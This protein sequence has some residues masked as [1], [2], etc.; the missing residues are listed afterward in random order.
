MEVAARR[1]FRAWATAVALV[2]G[3]AFL[4]LARWGG[5]LP[6][7][8]VWV[9]ATWVVVPAALI[10]LILA[11]CWPTRPGAPPLELGEGPVTLALGAGLYT[12]PYVLGLS[13]PWFGVKGALG[14]ALA[15]LAVTTLVAWA[16][17]A[18]LEPHGK[19]PRD[20]PSAA[21]RLPR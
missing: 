1:A 18:W 7:L 5:T 15:V 14:L 21:K 19:D 11:T 17:A 6:S 2:V 13:L 8:L 16:L 3:G 10:T 20:Q 12:V 4:V 9:L